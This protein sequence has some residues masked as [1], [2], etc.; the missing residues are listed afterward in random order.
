MSAMESSDRA[1][2][3]LVRACIAPL[4]L[5]VGIQC[6]LLLG[7]GDYGRNFQR[8]LLLAAALIAVIPPISRFYYKCIDCIR[9]PS[10]R[11]AIIVAIVI[12]VLA[13]CYFPLTAIYQGRV[14]TPKWQDEMSYLIQIRML[15]R[16]RLWM[17]MHPL[18][19]FFDSFQ[20]IV[21][22]VYASMYFPGASL[23]YVPGMW[24]HLPYW[25][26]STAIAGAC[27]GLMYLIA[28]DLIDGVAGAL[29]ALMTVSLS[30][31]RQFSVMVLG[32]PAII[33]LALLTIW[34]WLN[35][36]KNKSTCWA[37]AIGFFAGWAAITRPLDALVIAIPIGIDILFSQKRLITIFYLICGA[38][39]FLI[40]Q[41]IF[42]IGVTG[43]WHRTP[44]EYYA[45]RDYPGTTF[46]FHKFDPNLRPVSTLPQKQRFHD[47]WTISHIKDHQPDKVIAS[48]MHNGFKDLLNHMLP[49]RSLI[50]LLPLGFL[51][52]AC[53]KR[54]AVFAAFPLF[55]VLISFYT[56]LLPHYELI[57]LPAIFLLVL[58]G[59]HELE[60][61]WPR[62]RQMLGTFLSLAIAI[63]CLTQL[64]EL[65]RMVKDE[66]FDPMGLRDIDAKLTALAHKPAVVLFHFARDSNPH[67]EPVYNVDVAR[68]DDA[69]VIR[70]HD[71]GAKN[72]ELFDYYAEHQPDR[73]IYLYDRG[74]SS[75]K[76][77][78][79]AKDLAQK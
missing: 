50:A 2:S 53:R 10:P 67:E 37:I 28:T 18:A 36:R 17:P 22:P 64:A 30:M 1:L 63:V 52:L 24:L 60:N 15:A 61:A 3:P 39:P 7:A 70:A 68:P 69:L 23:F 16:G 38:A 59:A 34:C 25:I 72:I 35:W 13:A 33:L 78:G 49:H 62:A 73:A 11:A 77:L 47:E 76:F 31:F 44:F 56:F 75:L 79:F 51:G 14:L 42:N 45:D 57:T 27:V 32:H 41:I 48:W 4:L 65:N 26:T 5:I 19:N 9:R 40:L 20:L 55:I 6:W 12:S 66:M 71:L 54:I 8:E 21:D 29:A 58:L 74:D 43:S 46:G